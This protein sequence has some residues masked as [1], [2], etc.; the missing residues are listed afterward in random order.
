M[1]D[2]KFVE[3]KWGNETIAIVTAHYCV[4]V[5]NVK[6]GHKTSLQY[7][8]EKEESILILSGKGLFWAEENNQIIKHEAINSHFFH[9]PPG[10]VHRMEA[11]EEDL[12]FVECSTPQLE[13]VVRL[14]DDYGRKGTSDA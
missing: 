7:H 8:K 9:V 2:I 13:D 5:I 14:E 10:I 11:T 4:K 1:N 3:K 12:C 6:K